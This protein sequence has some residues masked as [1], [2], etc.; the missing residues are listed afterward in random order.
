MPGNRR[1]K[2]VN[3]KIADLLKLQSDLQ[4]V[5][6]ECTAI[7]RGNDLVV[8]REK[9]IREKVQSMLGSNYSE[10]SMKQMKDS[11]TKAIAMAAIS[12]DAENT[13]I[14]NIDSYG[15]FKENETN[16]LFEIPNITLEEPVKSSDTA[17]GYKVRLKWLTLKE[18]DDNNFSVR[19]RLSNSSDDDEKKAVDQWKMAKYDQV[20][21]IENTKF[22][23]NVETE[24]LFND[25]YEYSVGWNV[26]DPFPM[27][28]PS[29][30]V[31]FGIDGEPK[32]DVVKL[33]LQVHSHRKHYAG[34]HPNNLLLSDLS[35]YVSAD[36]SDFGPNENDWIIFNVYS[37]QIYF[38]K[39]VAIK[40]SNGS[41][42]VKTMKIWIGD[43]V[44]EWHLFQPSIINVAMNGN[45]QTFE[46]DGVTANVIRNKK[47]RHY[48]VEFVS[49]HG[50]SWFKYCVYEF[51]L[52]GMKY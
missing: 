38:P 15:I 24:M 7:L 51:Q 12:F 8:N 48:K 32:G 36:N 37:D 31:E 33:P 16:P 50:D 11:I 30:V 41:Q 21:K 5:K 13:L 6:H 46:I 49:N 23:V 22:A 14:C 26:T 10:N 2:S 3:S 45:M 42:G 4:N 28:I 17:N 9:K 35:Y 52:F 34:Y 27:T 19:F 18:A 47:L 43:G 20:E 40:N 44:N 39:K 25:K 1:K 29:N